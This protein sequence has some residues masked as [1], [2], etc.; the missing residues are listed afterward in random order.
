M[1]YKVKGKCVYKKDTGAKVGCTKGSV[2]KY[3]GAL[4]ANA[5]VNEANTLKGGKADKL[6]PKEIAKKF[7]VSVDKIEAQI[8][9]GIGVEMEHTNNKEKATEI[10]TDHVSE[11]PDYYDRLE[12]MEKKASKEFKKSDVTENTKKLIKHLIRENISNPKKLRMLYESDFGGKTIINVD[13]QPEY[14]KWFSFDVESWVQFINESAKNNKIVFLYNGED[15]LGMVSEND[16]KHWL[17]DLGIDEEI[18]YSATFYDKGYAFFR[19]CMDSNIDEDSIVDLVRFM[20]RHDINDSR[21]INNDMWNEYMEETNHTQEDVRE[22]L[23]NAG[24]MLSIPDLMD[25]LQGYNNIVL[26]GGGVDECLKEVEIALL[27]LDKQFNIL[28]KFTY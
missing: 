21:E 11:F 10:A 22:L 24:D 4:H 18:I 9:K 3:L 16:Y 1:P 17:Y 7:D 2:K 6:T 20:I 12:K 25:F 19:Y 15:T 8:K 23:E 14:E 27:A 13:I 26:T 5:D 28:S